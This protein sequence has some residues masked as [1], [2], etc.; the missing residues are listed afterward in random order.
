MITIKK[1]VSLYDFNAWQ[2]GKTTLNNIIE[3]GKIDMLDDL[4]NE[5]FEELT[6]TQ[7]N[8]LLWFDDLWLYEQLGMDE[9]LED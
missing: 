4:L 3:A 1:E 5:C 9:Y 2:G 6:E 8:D 7:L